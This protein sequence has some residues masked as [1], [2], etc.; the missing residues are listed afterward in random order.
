VIEWV[1]GWVG[2]R[3]A[4]VHHNGATLCLDHTDTISIGDYTSTSAL[5]QCIE[6]HSC[7]MGS[8]HSEARP[9][10]ASISKELMTVANK[11]HLHAHTQ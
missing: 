4:V 5:F 8:P 11:D 6:C 9:A 2:G 10:L 7:H 3:H 1:G